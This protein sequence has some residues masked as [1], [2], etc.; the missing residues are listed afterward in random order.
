MKIGYKLPN[1]AGVLCEPEWVMPNTL[2]DLARLAHGLGYESL[3]M[4]DHL[5]PPEEIQITEPVILEPLVLIGQ[6]AATIPDI[7]FGIAT[8]VLPL[9]DPVLLARQL[10]TLNM[11]FPNRV[12]AGVGVGR[13]KSEF[14]ACGSALFHERGKVTT[15]YIQLIRNLWEHKTSS[16]DGA[17]RSVINARFSPKP[18]RYAAVPIWVG[19]NSRAAIQRAASLGDGYVPAAKLPEEIEEDKALLKHELEKNSRDPSDFPMGLSLTIDF[20]RQGESRTRSLEERGMHGHGRE[21]IVSGGI[22]EITTR[23]NDFILAGVN[24][25]LL[26]FRASD[27]S[28]LKETMDRFASEVRPR[29]IAKA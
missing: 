28:E 6:L 24:H 17:Y 22:D 3:W 13:Y 12:I 20:P 19:G 14:L 11:L 5:L 9:R 29:L 15:E 1:C 16:F 25:F 18:N 8:L 27:L 26:S 4:H 7:L 2:V 10:A 23:L 21:R